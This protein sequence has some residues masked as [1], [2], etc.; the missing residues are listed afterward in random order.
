M[1]NLNE[2]S[3]HVDVNHIPVFSE[4]KERLQKHRI[5]LTQ[6][7]ETNY[8]L[9][10]HLYS[11]GVLSHEEFAD[12]NSVRYKHSVTQTICALLNV[13]QSKPDDV[14]MV[15]PFFKALKQTEQLHVVHFLKTDG[16]KS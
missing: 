7:M 14:D 6:T 8:G 5:K 15:E 9:L 13:L 2:K 1:T 10:D 11:L 16:G 4:L 12:I 3:T